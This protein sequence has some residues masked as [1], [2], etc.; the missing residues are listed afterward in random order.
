MLIRRPI[1][2]I[3]LL[4]LSA[5]APAQD[6]FQHTY[7]NKGAADYLAAA[8]VNNAEIVT[9]GTTPGPN[10]RNWIWVQKLTDAG[11]VI[12]SNAFDAGGEAEAVGILT[13]RNGYLLAYNIFDGDGRPQTA[14]WLNVDDNG[15]LR[16]NHHA[17]R[18]CQFHA[19]IA[20][21]SGYLF[22]GNTLDADGATDALALKVDE[23]GLLL[24]ANALGQSGEDVLLGVAADAD[25]AVYAV[26]YTTGDDNDLDGLVVQLGSSGTLLGFRHQYGGSGDDVLTSVA[27]TTGNRLLLGGHSQSFASVYRAF[28]LSAVEGTGT[29]RWSK[30][31]SIPE[32]SI[33]A[34]HIAPFGNARF[35]VTVNNP[36]PNLD[37][38][39]VV[40]NFNEE[41]EYSWANRYQ[42]TGELDQI[43][44]TIPSAK[45]LITIGAVRR[46]GD[47]DGWLQSLNPEG[48]GETGCCPVGDFRPTIK[49]VVP[50]IKDYLPQ[51]SATPK[52]LPLPALTTPTETT[53]KDLCID[54]SFS[55]SDSSICI[56]DCIAVN[57]TGNTPSVI[58]TFENDGAQGDPSQTGGIC[59]LGSGDFFLLRKGDNGFCKVVSPALKI[60]VSKV[61]DQFPNAFTPNG[62]SLNDVFKP[63]F[64]CPVQTSFLT[65][66]NRWGQKVFETRNPSEGWDGRVGGEDA[67]ADVYV[68]YVEYEA[69]RA[70]GRMKFV[71]KGDL[72]LL[73]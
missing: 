44:Q 26:G 57:I 45:G 11:T 12:W 5:A 15:Q 68:W 69:V 13:T 36:S 43:R 61:D 47:T 58:Y 63:L 27:L 20:L 50:I 67:P 48:L 51:F 25:D 28:W 35:L 72:T 21:K 9:A 10:G 14:G 38:R 29:V 49:D 4:H 16:W 7:N 22:V 18:R 34:T 59:Y 37:N 64:F 56:G 60:A 65:V 33:G 30:A 24:W 2:I 6:F 53:V 70:S 66:Y 46:D 54:L 1:F 23:D 19:A 40:F 42:T 71:K 8:V 32:Q 3:C 41:G 39:A 52:A 62:D 31:L 55:V 73:R 17:D